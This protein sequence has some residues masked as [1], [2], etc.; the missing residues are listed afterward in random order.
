MLFGGVGCAQWPVR[1]LFICSALHYCF[2]L[3]T[4]VWDSWIGPLG[5]QTTHVEYVNSALGTVPPLQKKKERK[6]K[7]SGDYSEH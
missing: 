5:E 6:V 1:A 7:E 3:R 2:C 4:C